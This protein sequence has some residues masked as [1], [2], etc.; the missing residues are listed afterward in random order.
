MRYAGLEWI[1]WSGEGAPDLPNEKVVTVICRDHYT[2]DYKVG[3]V[4]WSWQNSISDVM[5]YRLVEDNVN[6]APALLNEAAEIME[7]R[8]KQYDQKNGE[9]SMAQT[10]KAFNAIT[11]HNLS[12]ADGWEFMLILKQVRLFSVRGKTHADSVKDSVAYTALLGEAA[13]TKGDLN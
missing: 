7:E 4:D 1:D 2:Y 11:G 3:D 9:R 13:M 6:S 12:E 8:G 5:G 10:V